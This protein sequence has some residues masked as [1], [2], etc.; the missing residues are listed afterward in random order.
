MVITPRGP[1]DRLLT[2]AGAGALAPLASLAL[3]A[4]AHNGA[5]ASGTAARAGSDSVQVGYG[6]Q[7]RDKSTGAMTTLDPGAAPRPL[8][9][10]QLLRGKVAGLEIIQNGNNVTFRIRGG[11]TG[12]DP[13]VG[14]ISI[15]PLV[16]VDDAMVQQGNIMNALAGL[17]PD[18][19]KQVNV[20]K[21][22]ASTS[23]Y[24]SRGAGGVIIITT[25]RKQN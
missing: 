17:T 24:G 11:L 20:L 4:C 5:A 1:L 25:K 23:V 8:S 15:E 10:E 9:V 2:L 7:P 22:L 16:V 13:Q 21:D 6:A 14:G 3:A 19:I 12:V 18:D